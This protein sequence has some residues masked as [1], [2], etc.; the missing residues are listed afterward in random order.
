MSLKNSRRVFLGWIAAVALVAGCTTTPPTAD[1]KR[2]VVFGDSNVDNGNLF[3]LT[4]Q[5]FPAPPRWKGRD[6]NG[7]VV[8]EYLAQDLNAKLEDYAVS[9]ATTGTSNIVPLIVPQYANVASTGVSWQLDEF[10]KAG[11]KLSNSDLVVLWAGSNDIFGAK[12]QDKEDLAKRIAATSGNLEKALLRLQALGAKRIVFATRTPREVIGND[13]DL[14][15]VDLN[16]ALVA[17]VK[18]VAAKTGLDIRVYDSYDRISDMMKNP[19]KYGFTDARSLCVNVPACA[20]ENYES[21]LKVANTFV[22][23]DGAHK[24]TQVHKLMASEIKQMVSR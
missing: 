16:A 17:R 12:R 20:S 11:G 15:G 23:W 19:S 14:N 6:S 13:N 21:G 18:Q 4:S 8:V 1:I 22:N 2:V 5:K 3:R 9:G 10:S 24:T 7:P